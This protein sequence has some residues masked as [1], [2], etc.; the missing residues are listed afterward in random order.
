MI[1]LMSSQPND[2]SPVLRRLLSSAYIFKLFLPAALPPHSGRRAPQAQ[3]RLR[4]LPN[5]L[6]FCG[7]GFCYLN[8]GR[9]RF[10]PRAAPGALG[11]WNPSICARQTRGS[12][13]TRKKTPATSHIQW[14]FTSVSA[15]WS[16]SCKP[17]RR[18]MLSRF[19]PDRLIGCCSGS[20]MV[21]GPTKTPWVHLFRAC[22]LRT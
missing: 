16:D 8:D 14:L 17:K 9:H 10:G 20:V 13:L 22:S 19:C 5:A 6:L 21:L 7:C 15:S 4:L 1:S 18:V 2:S 11:S 3:T 12:G